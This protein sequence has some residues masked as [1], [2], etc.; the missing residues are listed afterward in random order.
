MYGFIIRSKEGLMKAQFED[1]HA[2]NL[3]SNVVGHWRDIT[4]EG[5]AKQKVY[6][7]DDDGVY[8]TGNMQS[9]KLS[10]Y[11]HEGDIIIPMK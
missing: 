5:E 11:I 8:C 3:I 6:E 1:G 10:I 4:Y 2:N 9:G 7:V